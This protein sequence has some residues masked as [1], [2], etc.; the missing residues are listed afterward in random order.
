MD[1]EEHTVWQDSQSAAMSLFGA[2]SCSPVANLWS[3]YQPEGHGSE[4][5][6]GM[7][8]SLVFYVS[9]D[10]CKSGHFRRFDLQKQGSGGPAGGRCGDYSTCDQAPYEPVRVCTV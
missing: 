2:A 8:G 10:F 4:K 7:H 5:I 9:T 3:C 1:D 6:R